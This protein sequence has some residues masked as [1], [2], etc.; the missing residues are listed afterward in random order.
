MSQRTQLFYVTSVSS[1]TV[2]LSPHPSEPPSKAG[3]GIQQITIKTTESTADATFWG[4][5]GTCANIY[6]LFQKH[7]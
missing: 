6:A 5:T 4:A 7:Q 1:D 2:T 3:L